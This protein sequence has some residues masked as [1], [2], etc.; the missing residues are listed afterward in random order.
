MRPS[1]Y[2]S[3]SAPLAHAA[4]VRT[5]LRRLA[6]RTY[7]AGASLPVALCFAAYV[8]LTFMSHQPRWLVWVDVALAVVI[9]FVLPIARGVEKRR[10][11]MKKHAWRTAM[12]RARRMTPAQK[13]VFGAMV[14][15]EEKRRGKLMSVEELAARL[16]AFGVDGVDCERVVDALKSAAKAGADRPWSDRLRL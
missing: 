6:W 9:G 7:R 10:A 14:D 13:A 11:A 4:A 8:A 12:E 3:S 1:P 5:P 2:R 15:R 16:G